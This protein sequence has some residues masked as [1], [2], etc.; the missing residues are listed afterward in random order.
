[1][2]KFRH[3]KFLTHAASWALILSLLL[4]TGYTGGSVSA[5]EPDTAV[6]SPNTTANASS[7]DQPYVIGE[8]ITKRTETEKHFYMSDG[9]YIAAVYDTP[10]HY[11]DENHTYQQIDNSLSESLSGYETKSGKQ[12]IKLA[13]KASAKKL[14]SITEEDYKISWGFANAKK[15]RAKITESA[16]SAND[17]MAVDNIIQEAI[18]ENA[19]ENA[20]LQYIISPNSVKEN[21]ILHAANAPCTFIQNY[22]IGQ[23][24]AVQTNPRTIELR[25]QGKTVYTLSAPVMTDAAGIISDALT[26]T[27]QSQKNGKLTVVLAADNAWLQSA[28]RV[29]PVTVDPG[30]TIRQNK[31]T[32]SS[33]VAFTNELVTIPDNIRQITDTTY[34]GC[35]PQL[36]EMI[37][38]YRFKSLPTLPAGSY[39]ANATFAVAKS[40]NPNFQ[41]NLHE[42]FDTWI[43]GDNVLQEDISYNEEVIDYTAPNAA[44]LQWDITNLVRYWYQIG[45]GNGKNNGFILQRDILMSPEAYIALGSSQNPNESVRPVLAISYVNHTGIESY[46]SYSTANLGAGTAYVDNATG[47]L[48]VELPLLSTKGKNMPAQLTMYYN[49]TQVGLHSKMITGAGW[50]NNYDQ[51]VDAITDS[52]LLQQKYYYTYT[53]ADGTVQY[54]K[55]SEKN[56]NEYQDE[57]GN[58]FTLKLENG[59]RI[60]TD[61]ENNQCIFD[62]TGKLLR[63]KSSTSSAA[64][65]LSYGSD[66]RLSTVTDGAGD[67]ICFVRNEFGAVVQIADPYNRKISL[68]YYGAKLTQ[69][70]GYD[71]SKISFTYDN[72][73]YLTAVTSADDMKV[74][75]EYWQATAPLWRCRVGA[76]QEQSAADSTGQRQK[77]DRLDILYTDQGYTRVSDK[78][79]NDGYYVFDSL[80]RA[81]NGFTATGAS[82]ASYLDPAAAQKTYLNN[83]ISQTTASAAPVENIALNSSFESGA[84]WHTWLSANQNAAASLATEEHKLGN[85]S[86]KLTAN[87][88]ESVTYYQYYLPNRSGT[89][90][91]SVYYKT[92]GI[93]ANEGISALIALEG[94]N[95]SKTYKRSR[96]VKESTNGEWERLTVSAEVNIDE[97]KLIHIINGL[98]YAT[99][100]VYFDCAQL[101]YSNT[102]NEYNMISN[103]SFNNDIAAWQQDEIGNGVFDIGYFIEADNPPEGCTKVVSMY[104]HR[105]FDRKVYQEI[106][107]NLPAS[108]VAL[109]FSAYAHGQ[110]V[111][112]DN[113]KSRH[114]ALDLQFK[115]S[116]GTDEYIIRSFD[117]HNWSWQRLT[118]L[119]L[120]SKENQQKTVSSVRAFLLYYKQDSC[121]EFTG[122][123]LTAD[124]SGTLYSYDDKGNPVSA[125]DSAKNAV[126]SVYDAKNRLTQ[127]T[128]QDGAVYNLSYNSDVSDQLLTASTGPKDQKTAYTYNSFGQVTSTVLSNQTVTD[129]LTMKTS[130]LYSANGKYLLSETNAQGTETGYVYDTN[131]FDNLQQVNHDQTNSQNYTAYTYDTADRVKTVSQK[132]ND[133]VDSTATVTYNY[134]SKNQLESIAHNGFQY[135]FLYDNY[136][137]TLQ[138]KVGA[139]TLITNT[140][141]QKDYNPSNDHLGVPDTLTEST[142]G[143]GAKVSYDYDQYG[144]VVQKRLNGSNAFDYTYLATGN[145]AR[146]RDYANSIVYEYEYD[147][148]GRLNRIKGSSAVGVC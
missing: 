74:C 39:I 125:V 106:P 142:Y 129:G 67:T 68:A 40:Q 137:N 110:P 107:I 3:Q 59:E 104:G 29:Y 76:I 133:A 126:N 55:Q 12:K 71:G 4:G 121:V 34:V 51:R 1:M 134:N 114:F 72:E 26:L 62:S 88:G 66:G 148:L 75:F 16:H 141:A 13:K 123:Q 112:S 115:Y 24:N 127:K 82:S 20:D 99:G 87:Q 147:A 70:T 47:N 144:R 50:R 63:M 10:V 81:I 25:N 33:A 6:S 131:G 103:G 96:M 139:R 101:E 79:T 80:G 69:I 119:F 23:L 89:Y 44:T 7:S 95:G 8:D 52:A 136:G 61:K 17:P 36:G 65:T 46:Y 94:K 98:H 122:V 43:D 54:F 86:L 32:L 130:S 116:D 118:E 83:K 56:A 105:T 11:L 5:A 9:T 138:N 28:E 41:I 78:N 100:A 85:R 19:F 84:S 27:L 14:V 77:G 37:S 57:L 58:G 92:D 21:I 90:T 35:H 31:S 124:T 108:K 22:E 146:L 102:A 2:N 42:C 64:I 30:I 140:Y 48:S 120:P 53:D 93:T 117:T 73:N 18:F 143:N 111:G 45:A 128:M 145:L 60:L 15:V 132:R 109:N 38:L 91:Y 113:D 97:V 135:G 49:G